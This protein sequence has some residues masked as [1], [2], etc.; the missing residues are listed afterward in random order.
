MDQVTTKKRA[1]HRPKDTHAGSRIQPSDD[2]EEEED[3][4]SDIDEDSWEC[5]DCDLEFDDTD[6]ADAREEQEEGSEKSNDSLEE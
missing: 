6:A 3:I 4:D 1:A 2:L 5:D